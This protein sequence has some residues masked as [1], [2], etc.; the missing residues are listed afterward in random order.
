MVCGA[1]AHGLAWL[2]YYSASVDSGQKVAKKGKR[3][4]IY[5]PRTSVRRQPCIHGLRLND[6]AELT[7]STQIAH[8]DDVK[9]LFDWFSRQL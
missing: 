5:S 7:S 6:V 9:M 1:T 3:M 4:C 2:E 8:L